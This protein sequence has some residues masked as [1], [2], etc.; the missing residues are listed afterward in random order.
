MICP[1]CKHGKTKK[2]FTTLTFEKDT[3]T[4]ILKKVPAYICDNC[5]ESFLSE[6]ISKKIIAQANQ[7]AGKGIEIEVLQYVA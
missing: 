4:I 2:G 7:K 5:N 3:T 6:E 1:I